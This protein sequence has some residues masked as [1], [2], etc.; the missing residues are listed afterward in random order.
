MLDKDSNLK[1]K[2]TRLF[3]RTTYE[4]MALLLAQPEPDTAATEPMLEWMTATQ[5]ARYWQLINAE[6]EATTAGI[7]KW[8]KR[9][10]EEHPL[11]HA[12]M[13]DLLRF[14]REEVD[15]WA[16]EE[17]ARRKAEGHRKKLQLA[18]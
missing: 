17:A 4:A 16:Q 15:R 12:C 9:S 10:D 14:K 5:L 3:D 11:P 7:M 2:L 6:G 1:E 18:S 13:G 8:A